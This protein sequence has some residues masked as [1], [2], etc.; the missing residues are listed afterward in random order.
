MYGSLLILDGESSHLVTQQ[1]LG[2]GIDRFSEHWLRDRLFEHP[3]V[4]PFEELDGSYSGSVAVCREM[5]TEA[6]PIDVLFANEHGLL[7][8]LECK[9]WRNP[10]ARREVVG[11]VLDYARAMARLT[12]EDLSRLVNSAL[13]TEGN[14]LFEI[15]K[16]RHSSLEEHVWVDQ[17]SRNLSQGRFLLL[18][19][20]DG[21]REGVV[22]I[23]EQL[24]RGVGLRFQF[25]LVE[26]AVF[27]DEA[28]PLTI[29][30]PRLLVRTVN[31]E[32]SVVRIEGLNSGDEKAAGVTAAVLDVDDAVAEGGHSFDT[33]LA[34]V[35]AAFWSAFVSKV[36]LEG[37]LD[38]TPKRLQQNSAKARLPLGQWITAYRWE[39][40]AAIGLFFSPR[41][42]QA[43]EIIRRLNARRPEIE[44]EIGRPVEWNDEGSGSLIEVYREENDFESP[45]A[46]A[47]QH[48]WLAE[49][50]KA[51]T[52][53]LGPALR[54]IEQE[55]SGD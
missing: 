29:L 33:G 4:L 32:R 13:G 42:D 15:V 53:V 18:V 19:A 35:R 20:G 27:H 16:H 12:Y 5:R 52:R 43:P 31:V 26:V 24:Q 6:G 25:G 39:K 8:I 55:L 36:R 47:V 37:G 48:E 2:R 44:A 7:T 22:A 51:F 46:L 11:Q 40:G 21:I 10:E 49:H 50:L 45:A 30:Q 1:A 41:G 3:D 14:R 9:L 54:S 28:A 23:T 17:V 34:A 38:S